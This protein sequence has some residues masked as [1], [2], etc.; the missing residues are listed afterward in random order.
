MGLF[1]GEK[2]SVTNSTS[3]QVFKPLVPEWIINSYEDATKKGLELAN[4]EYNYTADDRIAGFSP[5]ELAAYQMARDNVGKYNST[6]NGSLNV[7]NNLAANAINGPTASQVSN[8]MNPY[9]QNVVD[10]ERNKAVEEADRQRNQLNQNYITSQAFGGSRN[11]VANRELGKDLQNQLAEIQ[12][13]GSYNAYNQAMGQYNA[14]VGQ[15]MQAASGAMNTA[16]QASQMAA[17]DM[18]NLQA[19]GQQNRQMDQSVKDFNYYKDWVQPM[20]AV[21]YSQQLLNSVPL[22]MYGFR[23]DTT[24]RSTTTQ[25]DSPSVMSQVGGAAMMAAGVM[26]GN[27]MLMAAGAQTMGGSGGGG[28]GMFSGG[29]GG[30]SPMMSGTYGS[31]MSSPGGT[32]QVGPELITWNKA[33]GGL[34]D[35]NN[36][37]TGMG[38]SV[39]DQL[40]GQPHKY[41]DGGLVQVFLD[42]VS[43]GE[44][45][46]QDV[47]NQLS[48]NQPNVM[49]GLLGRVLNPLAN[50]LPS[51]QDALNL[52][53]Q[54]PALE[55]QAKA[56]YDQGMQESNDRNLAMQMEKAGRI[57]KQKAE[58]AAQ[59]KQLFNAI[60]ALIYG[61]PA[62]ETPTEQTAVPVA[63]PKG[64]QPIT[65]D[66]TLNPT[67]AA[68]SAPSS[69]LEQVT[70]TAGQPSLPD[71]P[72]T[73]GS[74]R[75]EDWFD[76]L[77]KNANIPMIQMGL[78]MMAGEGG[79]NFFQDLA[80][81]GQKALGTYKEQENA[82]YNQAKE[83]MVLE[84]EQQK[85]QNELAKQQALEAYRAMQ[86]EDNNRRMNETERHNRAMEQN[87]YGRAS[88]SI[89]PAKRI[90]LYNAAASFVNDQLALNPR[91]ARE[92]MQ[93]KNKYRAMVQEEADRRIA[94]AIE[95]GEGSIDSDQQSG[96]MG[97]TGE[98]EAAAGVTRV[99]FS[100][101]FK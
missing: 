68:A 13:N 41:A 24:S 70:A 9:M 82:V 86:A 71:R 99:S 49:E 47:I 51:V 1:S 59:D 90:S 65:E 77:I 37:D 96:T 60:D 64:P 69:P 19:V 85:M 20:E 79:G 84:Q 30:G 27:P 57:N 17:N 81:G 66:V 31:Q 67:G 21:N 3:S 12:A 28:G 61:Q 100:D 93:D 101:K 2:K 11:A 87:G 10:I 32:S 88:G 23:N 52:S 26:T 14:G 63:Q 74:G 53:I 56:M 5:D 15:A 4:R 46:K 7:Y 34:V 40:I 22:S 44:M 78:S 80:V 95:Q 36:P 92:V 54:A 62:S 33:E 98:D 29:F 58:R 25:K 42:K 35:R 48:A 6:L 45:S 18:N 38:A 72:I 76:R 55:G 94:F 8:L 16:G 83:E 97:T 39:L 73:T 75:Q 43:S 50:K 91:L 89:T